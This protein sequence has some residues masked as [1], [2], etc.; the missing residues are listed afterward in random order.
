MGRL[1]SLNALRAFEAASRH[2]NFRLA[3]EELGVTQGAVAQQI[4]GLEAALDMKLFE[5]H[6]RALTLTE[7]GRRYAGGVRRA[8]EMLAEATQALRPA[9]LRLTISVTPTLA[10]K[11]LIPRLPAFLETHPDID[12]RI[13]ATDR[14]SHFQ[15]DAVDLAVRY[16]KPPF[17]SGLAVDLLFE[18]V[19]VAVASPQTIAALGHPGETG[20]LRGHALLHDAHNAWPQFLELAMP[21]A[22]MSVAKNVRF[23]QT[24][25]AIDAAVAGQGLA[26][27][28]TDFI[29]ADVAAGRLIR[30]FDTELR[31]GAGFYIVSPRRT[32]HAG[33]IADVREWLLREAPARRQRLSVS[34]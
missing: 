21:Q 29:V 12:L 31:T 10:S 13:L 1:P 7:N 19:Q 22:P 27:A 18:E 34:D 26:L 17:G 8:F 23:N 15:A 16:G 14:L 24:A 9:P 30:L 20:S 2:L 4:R 25:L 5:R 33:P 6:P 3:A 32:R 28:H 11:W